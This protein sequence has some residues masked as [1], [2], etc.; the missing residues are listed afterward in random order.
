M[1]LEA[2]SFADSRACLG[3]IH[4]VDAKHLVY[5]PSFEPLCNIEP[6]YSFRKIF[7]AS[8]FRERIASQYI[9]QTTDSFLAQNVMDI[10]Q[11]AH[12]CVQRL[13]RKSTANKIAVLVIRYSRDATEGFALIRR[14]RIP[15]VHHSFQRVW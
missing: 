11:L 10:A 6:N 2:C 15:P 14:N 9:G 1:A 7:A 4:I 5:R 8:N 3:I 12:C 13:R